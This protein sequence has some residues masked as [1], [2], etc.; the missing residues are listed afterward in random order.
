MLIMKTKVAT[1][2]AQETFRIGFTKNKTKQKKKK[3]GLCETDSNNAREKKHTKSP[4]EEKAKKKGQR[5]KR[6]EK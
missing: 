6:G 3:P 4:T 2:Y 1:G 5:T